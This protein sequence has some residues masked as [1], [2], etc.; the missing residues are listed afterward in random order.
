MKDELQETA[1]LKAV[2]MNQ[3]QM[4]YT[5]VHLFGPNEPIKYGSLTQTDSTGKNILHH[6]VMN[7]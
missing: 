6:A 4:V 7:K 3:M 5:I 1:L 2:R